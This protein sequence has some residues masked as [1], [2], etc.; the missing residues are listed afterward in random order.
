[1]PFDPAYAGAIGSIES[2]GNYSALGPSTKGGDRAYGKYQVMGD[3]V[4]PWTKDI[5]GFS[6]TPAEFLKSPQAQDAVF[7]AK[8]GSYVDKY[9]NP[10]DAASAWFTGRPLAQGATSSDV[11]GTTGAKY[12]DLFNKALGQQQVASSASQ[13]PATP[14]PVPSSLTSV[15]SQTPQQ[16]A[17]MPAYGWSPGQA[18]PPATPGN[19]LM[20][21]MQQQA[22]QQ[23]AAPAMPALHPLN[24]PVRPPPDTSRIQLALSQLPANVRAS[25]FGA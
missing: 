23:P 22:M 13:P 3:N 1:M 6:M 16:P 8:F 25:Y 4:G 7:Q 24:M 10:Q 18:I 11:T 2:G 20:G 15:L 21:Q 5:L 14:S 17:T 9:G 12:V 19:L